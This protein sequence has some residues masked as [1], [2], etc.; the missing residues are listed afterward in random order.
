MIRDVAPKDYKKLEIL[1]AK[2]P[3]KYEL[4]D[5]TGKNF[6]MGQVVVDENDDPRILLC[7]QR[8]AEAQV[9]IDHEF[10][11]PHFRLAALGEL[12]AAAKPRMIAMG[13]D[14]SIGTVGPDVPRRYLERL[15]GLGCGIFRDW[16]MV[17]MWKAAR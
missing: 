17:K 13:Y 3:A 11:V 9:V 4:M 12:I 1:H 2:A 6:I 14:D 8:T 16:T 15:K 7:F 10:D 5:F